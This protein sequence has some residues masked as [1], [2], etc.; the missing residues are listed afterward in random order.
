MTTT[1]YFSLRVM[2]HLHF[3]GAAEQEFGAG[4]FFGDLS[5]RN[6]QFPG[7]D[8]DHPRHIEGTQAAAGAQPGAALDGIVGD[9]RDGRMDFG[10]DLALR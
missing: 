8:F 10:D 5:R 9:G 6:A 1:S 2:V 4:A 3:F 7:Q